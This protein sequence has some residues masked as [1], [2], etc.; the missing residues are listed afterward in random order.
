MRLRKSFHK[1][2]HRYAAAH[3][4]LAGCIKGCLG[5]WRTAAVIEDAS[6]KLIVMADV[7]EDRYFTLFASA[8]FWQFSPMSFYLSCEETQPTPK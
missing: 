8:L 7:H 5:G 6:H 4:E 1:A 3:I 2:G